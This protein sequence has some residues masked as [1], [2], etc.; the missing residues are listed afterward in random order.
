MI[1]AIVAGGGA[2]LQAVFEEA[3]LSR[4]KSEFT[5]VDRD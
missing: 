5:S 3:A 2:E 4:S 1:E